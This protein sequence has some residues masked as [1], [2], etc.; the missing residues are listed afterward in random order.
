MFGSNK[1]FSSFSYFSSHHPLKQSPFLLLPGQQKPHEKQPMKLQEEST[2]HH[3]KIEMTRRTSQ[4]P[5]AKK[6]TPLKASE[7]AFFLSNAKGSSSALT[8]GKSVRAL[9]SYSSESKPES[10]LP[11]SGIKESPTLDS[12][13][14]SS[15]TTTSA[16]NKEPS[17]NQEPAAEVTTETDKAET[18]QAFES[19]KKAI[20]K[21]SKNEKNEND[22]AE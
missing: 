18:K 15:N 14:L 12:M 1:R 19:L 22:Y 16:D 21:P 2:I 6:E 4:I 7:E 13:I 3:N 8:K 10:L 9:S 17:K 20:R 5:I 11:L